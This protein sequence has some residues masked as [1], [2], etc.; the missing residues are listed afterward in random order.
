MSLFQGVIFIGDMPLN[1]LLLL[2]L[3]HEKVFSACFY[4]KIENTWIINSINE[5]GLVL[6]M[7]TNWWAVSFHILVPLMGYIMAIKPILV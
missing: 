6:F 1:A 3:H 4:I 5:R 7:A 2:C